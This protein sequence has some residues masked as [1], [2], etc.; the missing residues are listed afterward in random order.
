MDETVVSNM[1]IA[2]T[3]ADW[4]NDIFPYCLHQSSHISTSEAEVAGARGC[5]GIGPLLSSIGGLLGLSVLH[6]KVGMVTGIGPG[7]DGPS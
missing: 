5:F 1:V 2:P 7:A 6:G 3:C 4:L